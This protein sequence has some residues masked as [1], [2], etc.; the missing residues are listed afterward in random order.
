MPEYIA[1]IQV[2]LDT[3]GEIQTDEILTDVYEIG[4]NW[5]RAD[6]LAWHSITNF[7]NFH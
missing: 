2:E 3:E 4:F 1:Y 6:I 5:N 7:V